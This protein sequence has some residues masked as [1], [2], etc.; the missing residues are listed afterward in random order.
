[1]RKIRFAGVL[2]SAALSF[3]LAA[4]ADVTLPHIFGSHMVLQQQKPVVVW[5]T[6]KPGESVTVQIGAAQ[7]KT[8]ASDAGEWRAVLPPMK[9]GGPFTMTVR[10]ANTL[11]LDDV[12]VGE[13]WLCSGQSNMELGVTGCLNGAQEVAAANHPGIRLFMVPKIASPTPLRDVEG[14][15]KICSPE[16]IAAGGWAGFTGAGYYFGRELNEKLKVPVGLIQSAYGGTIIEAWTPP[17]VTATPDE[18]KAI[19]D[20]VRSTDPKNSQNTPTALYNGMIHPLLPF[21]LRG[22]IWYQGESNHNDG[23]AYTVKMKDL[24]ESWRRLWDDK[25]MPF[26]YTQIAP[27]QYGDEDP[28]IIAKFWKAQEAAMAVIPNSGMIGTMDIGNIADI[29]PTNKQDIGRRLALWALAKTYGQ[30]EVVCSGPVFKSMKIEGNKLRLSFENTGGGLVSRDGKPLSWFEVVDALTGGFVK[31]DAVIDK[32]TVVV[33]AAGVENPVSVRFGWS[34]F[35]E[36]NLSNKEGLPALPFRAGEIPVRDG[37]AHV[38]EARGFKLVYDLDLAKLGPEPTYDVD[39]HKSITGQIDRIAYFIELL[40]GRGEEQYLYVSMDAFTQDLSQIGVPTAGSGAHFQQ[41][42]A[43]MNVLSNVQGIVTG[44]GLTGGNI[45]FW[46]NNYGPGNSTQVPNASSETYDFGDIPD[47]GGDYG[48]MQV[49]N[50]D[51]KQTLFALNHWKEGARADLGIGNRPDGGNAPDW[52]FAANAD[53]CQVK[54]LRVL[55]HLQAN[56]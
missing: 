35:A 45:E 34:K 15:W 33:S 24:V 22:A 5:G 19:E 51:A 1:M 31:A 13:V 12:M 38:A 43:A 41:D 46:P 17:A 26:Y 50:H 52:T 25:A 16:S 4:S 21:A 29:H 23:D 47:G 49:H 6:A 44:T 48:S 27:C 56:K 7:Q 30:R 18:L 40:N 53:S 54:R 32:N 2:L 28:S 3:T 9:A 8:V 10:A 20:R 37:L 42:V 39:N 55:V 11:T 14:E 36:P